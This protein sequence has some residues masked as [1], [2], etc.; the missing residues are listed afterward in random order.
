[1]IYWQNKD[2]VEVYVVIRRKIVFGV[3]VGCMCMSM[4]TACGGSKETKEDTN[5]NRMADSVV[6]E[7]EDSVS[8]D[9]GGYSGFQTTVRELKDLVSSDDFRFATPNEQQTLLSAELAAL[10]ENGE[11]M[12][13]YSY[14]SDVN[15]YDFITSDGVFYTVSAD[16]VD[17]QK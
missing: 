15:G 9:S 6:E 8:E 11:I 14:N 4:L 3:C 13:D 2:N 17:V 5:W 7:D 12:S 16:G 1:M 10:A